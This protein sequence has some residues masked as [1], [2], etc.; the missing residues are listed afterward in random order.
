MKRSLIL[1]FLTF[2]LVCFCGCL[3][4]LRHSPPTPEKIPHHTEIQGEK[5]LDNYHWLKNRSSEDVIDYIKAENKYTKKVMSD[6]AGLREELFSEMTAR[7]KKKDKTVPVKIDNY[8]YYSKLIKGKDYRIYCRKKESLDAPEEVILNMNKLAKDKK[9]LDLGVYKVSPNHRLLAYSLDDSGDERYTLH[10]KDLKTGKKLEDTIK[11]TDTSLEWA[12]GGKTV[13]YTVP[14]EQNRP[15]KVK[16]HLLGTDVSSDETILRE[17]R[18]NFYLYLSKSKDEKY[19]FASAQSKVTTE[20]HFMRASNPEGNFNIVEPRHSEMEYYVGHHGGSFYIMTNWKAE[21]YRIM[22]TPVDSPGRENWKN[23]V[24]KRSGITING[25]DLFEDY[26]VLEERK[27]GLPCLHIIGLRGDANYYIDFPEPSY[28]LWTTGN[29][30]F[31]TQTLRFG[32]SSFIRPRSIYDYNMKNRERELKK[33]KEVPGYDISKY[34]T[35]RLSAEAR[36]GTSVPISVVYK[37]NNG[38]KTP[39]PLLLK[40]YGAYGTSMDPYFSTTDLSLLNRGFKIAIAHIRGGGEKGKKWHKAG[41]MLNKKNTFRDFIDSAEF[42]IEKNYTTPNK[43]VINGGSAGGMLIGAVVNMRPRLFRSAVADV[44]F[45]DVLNTMLDE[46]IPLTV[47]EY[48]EWGNP[49]K[50]TYYDYIKSYSPY[51]NI[52]KQEYPNILA[53]ASM[54]DARVQYWEPAKWIAKLREYN[55]GDSLILLKMEMVAGHGGSS[56]RYNYYR[57]KAFKYAFILK[58]LGLI[59]KRD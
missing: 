12:S 16:R 43:L 57:D 2:C 45:V 33:Q 28:S 11:N 48:E 54:N 46:T 26:I 44:P 34:K 4:T 13:F 39:T 37:K 38:T 24:P 56:G 27:D 23:F 6:T 32:Y 51:D 55:T 9:Y 15:H 14:D 40:G 8:F 42:L 49:H 5:L 7:I 41:R 21:N 22:K 47:L 30:E 59:Q 19:I 50:K 1:T 53:A 3:R 18:E 10:F 52:K 20:I 17:S 58:T 29:R 35:E 36:D 25:F 31:N